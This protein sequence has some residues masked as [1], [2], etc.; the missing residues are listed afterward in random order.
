[1]RGEPRDGTALAGEPHLER[2]PC[3]PPP[4]AGRREAWVHAG[5][6]HAAAEPTT[7][8]TVLGSCVSVCLYD[9][10]AAVGGLNHYLLPH[11]AARERSCRFGPPA[12][13]ALLA[14]VLAH[15]ARRERL[16]AKVFGGAAVMG[17]PRPGRPHLGH[18]NVRVALARL[19]ELG[20]PVVDGDV[21][22]TR[23]R[24]LLFHTDDGSAW[25]RLL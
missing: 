16:R 18:E 10:E 6:L 19:G 24:K 12:I 15:G 20:V 17:A 22:G 1:M 9:P 5:F 23:G 7:V 25:V 8:A 4:A 2:P 21:G 3:P 14:A 13:D 11:D